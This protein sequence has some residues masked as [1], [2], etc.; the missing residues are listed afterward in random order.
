MSMITSASVFGPIVVPLCPAESWYVWSIYW[1]HHL[2]DIGMDPAF[3]GLQRFNKDI[4]L[5][6]HPATDEA[7]ADWIKNCGL[8]LA[9]YR[10]GRDYLSYL[11][12]IFRF[13]DP[14]DEVLYKL[15][16]N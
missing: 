6:S 5:F 4:A 15:L 14:A 3:V 9:W 7:Q 16:Y 12:L 1:S 2:C 10:T 8:E 13:R 11:Y